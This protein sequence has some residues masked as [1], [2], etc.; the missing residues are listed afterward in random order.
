MQSPSMNKST[1]HFPIATSASGS[2]LRRMVAPI[3]GSSV[4]KLLI[5]A[6]EEKAEGW[7]TIPHLALRLDNL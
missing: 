7:L 2:Y 5:V 1:H 4:P 6:T 3:A